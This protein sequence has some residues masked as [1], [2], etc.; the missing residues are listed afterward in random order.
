MEN[1]KV[2]RLMEEI[3]S[4]LDNEIIEDLDDL[5]ETGSIYN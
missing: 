3:E 1:I 2:I 5:S 4:D